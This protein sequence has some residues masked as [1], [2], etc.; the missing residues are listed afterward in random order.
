MYTIS[1]VVADLYIYLV[2]PRI[3]SVPITIAFH[4]YCVWPRPRNGYGTLYLFITCT[5]HVVQRAVRLCGPGR[6]A[7]TNAG[8]HGMMPDWAD[9]GT[10]ARTKGVHFR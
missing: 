5:L 4:L 1:P 8:A 9:T 3:Q 7:F 2:D 10:P 6:G